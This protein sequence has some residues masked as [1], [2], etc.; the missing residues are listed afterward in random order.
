MEF[1]YNSSDSDDEFKYLPHE[2]DFRESKAIRN[3]ESAMPIKNT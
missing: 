3:K 2:D 1:E